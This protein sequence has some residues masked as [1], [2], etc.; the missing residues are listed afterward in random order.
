MARDLIALVNAALAGRYVLESETGKGAA[1]RV[2]RARDASGRAVALKVLRPELLVSVEAARFLREIA[3]ASQLDHPNIAP[4]LDSGSEG[5]VVYYVMAF[6]EGPSLREALDA[7]PPMEEARVVRLARELLGALEHAHAKGIVHRD[8]KPE[9]IILSPT[10]GAVLLDFGIARAMAASGG[11]KL[12]AVGTTVG[13]STYMSPEQVRAVE[14][15]DHRSDL[16]SLGCVLYEAL[17]GRPPF[18]HEND[19]MVMQ[20][21]L[22][23]PPADLAA[24]RPGTSPALAAAIMRALAKGR[25]ERWQSAAEMLGALGGLRETE[26][27]QASVN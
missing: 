6:I 5:W 16:Y 15:P 21:H 3:V 11:E 17:A 23:Q 18:V 9:N 22:S 4:L 13:T 24:V 25:E 10:A 7:G 12:T 1:A 26:K 2:Y 20:M 8:V 27:V 14:V 19:V